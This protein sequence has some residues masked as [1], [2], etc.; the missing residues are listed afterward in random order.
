MAQKCDNRNHQLQRG[1][2]VVAINLFNEPEEVRRCIEKYRVKYPVLQGDEATQKA[3]IEESK[4]WATFFVNADGK[5]V[6]KIK[7]SINNGL[8]EPVFRVCG[9]PSSE[10]N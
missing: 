7:D 2:Q 5:I 6:K 8:E 9:L 10:V 4:A 1:L 3:W